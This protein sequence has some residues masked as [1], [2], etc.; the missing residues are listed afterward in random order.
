MFPTPASDEPGA[1]CMGGIK[2]VDRILNRFEA[3]WAEWNER[4]PPRIEDYLDG[5]GGEERAALLRELIAVEAEI[6]ARAGLA[7]DPDDVRR[8]FPRDA[9]VIERALRASADGIRTEDLERAMGLRDRGMAEARLGA[10][11]I[12]PPARYP[13]AVGRPVG[14]GGIGEVYRATD[15][16]FGRELAV[17]VL[18]EDRADDPMARDRF[19]REAET[20]ARLQHPGIVP[21]YGL[22]KQEDGRLFYAM[23]YITGRTLLDAIGQFHG[24]GAG[25]RD[26][27]RHPLETRA[28]LSRFVSV[29]ETIAYAHGQGV[30][31]R[32]IK[33]A[34]VMLGDFGETIVI[35]WGMSRGSGGDGPAVADGGPSPTASVAGELRG[36]LAYMSPEQALGDP[37]R[38]DSR[39]DLFA[40]GATL[41]HILTGREPYA[42]E[43]SAVVLMRVRGGD[44][45]RPRAIDRRIPRPLESICLRAMASRPDD[46]YGSAAELATEVERWL[47]GERVLAHDESPLERLARLFWRH[48]AGALAATAAAFTVL[49]ALVVIVGMESRSQ[50]RIATSNGWAL[51]NFRVAMDAVRRYHSGAGE[52]LLKREPR[53]GSLRRE[54]LR[55]SRAFYR[56]IADDLRRQDARGVEA[57]ETLA[58]A[59]AQLGSIEDDVG[60]AADALAIHEDARSAWQSLHDEFPDVP[61]YRVELAASLNEVGRAARR[62]DLPSR[63]LEAFERARTILADAPAPVRARADARLL[64]AK[65]ASNIATVLADKGDVDGAM[66]LCDEARTI[67]ADLLG[68]RPAGLDVAEALAASSR[69]ENNIATLKIQRGDAE[70]AATAF[71]ATAARFGE[72]A[73]MRPEDPDPARL[74]AVA[75]TNHAQVIYTMGRAE[76]ADRE[77]AEARAIL[78]GLARDYPNIAEI[79][80][81]LATVHSSLGNLR[82]A[83]GKPAEAVDALRRSLDL[84]RAAAAPGGASAQD[85]RDLAVT[86]FNL[87]RVLVSLGRVEEALPP[88]QDARGILEGLLK[89]ESPDARVRI[90]LAHC[91][92]HIGLCRVRSRP[93]EASRELLESAELLEAAAAE[94]V[95]ADEFNRAAYLAQCLALIPPPRRAE[96]APAMV[97]RVLRAIGAARDKGITDPGLYESSREFDPIRGDPRFRRFLEELRRPGPEPG[98][99]PAGRPS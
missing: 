5:M 81:D 88:L 17:K 83:Q 76:E 61:R 35:D 40:L 85:L 89:G 46:R 93:D 12:D 37:D 48:R 60:T 22:G 50:R 45:P 63:A 54:M 74:R 24:G 36:T 9:V 87:G 59:H 25:A 33:P 94:T 11:P 41:Y 55:S 57:R 67:L 39:S 6:R 69:L 72:L 29:C 75:L 91:R 28:L 73:R 86:A 43:D 3:D 80:R 84:H 18:Q 65:V 95:G 4:R 2:Q 15:V 16:I 64:L 42:G 53:L 47:A 82:E 7:F 71:E 44:F 90:D 13:R 8:R 30:I 58:E 21:I 14:R 92:A 77:L 10:L 70:G 23:R 66:P 34:N 68:S 26:P 96:R 78:D 27:F 19:I 38:I 79:G 99:A 56:T 20:T 62:G 51:R 98:P 31:H 49:L 97:D 32:D 52:Y 1:D